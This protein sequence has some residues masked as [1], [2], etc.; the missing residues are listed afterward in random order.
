[1][2]DFSWW[3]MVAVCMLGILG[4]ALFASQVWIVVVILRWMGVAI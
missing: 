1:M 3:F 2:R 4:I